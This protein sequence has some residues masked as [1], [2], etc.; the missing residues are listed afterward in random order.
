VS[1]LF[2]DSYTAHSMSVLSHSSFFLQ[3]L[4]IMNTLLKPSMNAHASAGSTAT[5]RLL[6]LGYFLGIQGMQ[7]RIPQVVNVQFRARVGLR[8]QLFM[9]ELDIC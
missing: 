9:G 7:K 6:H 4:E 3:L 8:H 1:Q 2:Q 5:D